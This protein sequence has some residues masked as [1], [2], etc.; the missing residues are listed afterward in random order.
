MYSSPTSTL[1]FILQN[2]FSISFDELTGHGSIL[3]FILISWEIWKKKW[4]HVFAFSCNCD[5]MTLPLHSTPCSRQSL[6]LLHNPPGSSPLLAAR[7]NKKL[8]TKAKLKTIV[9][10]TTAQ[11]LFIYLT[12]TFRFSCKISKN[13]TDHSHPP[14]LPPFPNPMGSQHPRNFW[15]VTFHLCH[16]RFLPASLSSDTCLQTA[17]ERLLPSSS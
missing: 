2:K 1:T 11:I 12:T 6:C 14:P 13:I 10:L 3:H 17:P 5:K 7:T 9:A 16:F 8:W 4:P 15:L